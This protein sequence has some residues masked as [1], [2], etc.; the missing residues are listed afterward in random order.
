MWCF[1]CLHLYYI[2]NFLFIILYHYFFLLFLQGPKG[3]QGPAGLPGEQ[4]SAAGSRAVC[5]Y[6][7]IQSCRL[8]MC[9]AAVLKPEEGSVVT[10]ALRSSAMLLGQAS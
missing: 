4:V 8:H 9:F 1:L 5:V 2:T 3:Y 7:F 6:M 10:V